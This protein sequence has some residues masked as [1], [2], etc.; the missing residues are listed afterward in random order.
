VLLVKPNTYKTAGRGLP[1][2]IALLVKEALYRRMCRQNFL[3]IGYHLFFLN[4]LGDRLKKTDR[5]A[6]LFFRNVLISCQWVEE[7]FVYLSFL[8]V[9]FI[10]LFPY[11]GLEHVFAKLLPL[12]DSISSPIWEMNEY[13]YG[14]DKLKRSEKNLFQYLFS[15]DE[16]LMK[17]SRSENRR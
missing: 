12:T 13:G 8:H 11:G 17:F 1:H 3:G 10:Y 14:Q 5:I 15:S 16:Y 7:D 6:Y 4:E 9:Y 2:E